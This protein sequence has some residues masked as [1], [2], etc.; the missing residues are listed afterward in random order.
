MLDVHGDDLEDESIPMCPTRLGLDA[1]E[2]LIKAYGT[3]CNRL[4]QEAGEEVQK[5]LQKKLQD[6]ETKVIDDK[7]E[8][9]NTEENQNEKVES[10]EARLWRLERESM[11]NAVRDGASAK[12]GRKINIEDVIEVAKSAESVT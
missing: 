4:P 9:K 11:E 7:I 8:Q 2:I 10:D 12:A 1:R 5:K 6:V 3:S